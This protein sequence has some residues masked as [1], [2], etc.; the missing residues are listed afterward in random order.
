MVPVS[1]TPPLSDPLRPLPG[2]GTVQRDESGRERGAG[3]EPQIPRLPG[4]D[5]L[6]AGGQ[7]RGD[8]DVARTYYGGGRAAAV[9]QEEWYVC[10]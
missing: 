2:Q 6:P 3:T 10:L 1:L 9:S 5:L 8:G 4:P 7:P